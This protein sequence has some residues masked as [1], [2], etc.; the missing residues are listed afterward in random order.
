MMILYDHY[1]TLVVFGREEAEKGINP[2]QDIKKDQ[3]MDLL[4]NEEPNQFGG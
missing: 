4:K 2:L 3:I 1:F